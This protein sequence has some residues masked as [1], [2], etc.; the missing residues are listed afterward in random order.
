MSTS[1]WTANLTTS[2]F[3]KLFTKTGGAVFKGGPADFL[4]TASSSSSMVSKWPK[5]FFSGSATE[6]N[7]A[8]ITGLS[9]GLMRLAV[10]AVPPSDAEGE[11]LLLFDVLRESGWVE[12]CTSGGVLW[13]MR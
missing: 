10:V 3:S 12:L 6:L 7:S 8:S 13:P 2:I 1:S 5:V 4:G 11:K 9:S